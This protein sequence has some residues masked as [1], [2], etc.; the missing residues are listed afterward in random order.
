LLKG[1]DR[2]L[3]EAMRTKG[4]SPPPPPATPPPAVAAPASPA[5]GGPAP[6]CKDVGGYEAYKQKTGN[7][8]EI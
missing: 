1:H 6:K 4:C 2:A 7:V 8:C 3:D 5:P